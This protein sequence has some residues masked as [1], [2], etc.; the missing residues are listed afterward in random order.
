MA[1]TTIDD[2]SDLGGEQHIKQWYAEKRERYHCLIGELGA[3]LRGSNYDSCLWW[4]RYNPLN[5]CQS[6]TD[7]TK[8]TFAANPS[9]A[10]NPKKRKITTLARLIQRHFVQQGYS[11]TDKEIARI[12][13]KFLE[14]SK[15]RQLR[16]EILEGDAILDAYKKAIGG[17]S[18]MTERQ[19][20]KVVLYAENSDIIKLVTAYDGKKNEKA[21]SARAL[22]WFLKDKLILDRIYRSG[23]I[24]GLPIRE[25][26]DKYASF[27]E[28]QFPKLTV[29]K[30]KHNDASH[31]D[32]YSEVYTVRIKEPEDGIWPYLDSFNS[33]KL[34]SKGVYELTTSGREGKGW[35]EVRNQNG[36]GP[37]TSRCDECD[38]RLHEDNLIDQD[39]DVFCGPCHKKL[40]AKCDDCGDFC[41]IDDNL[42]Q[43]GTTYRPKLKRIDVERYCYTCYR[44]NNRV[45]MKCADIIH[46]NII[47]V[48]E[49]AEYCPICYDQLKGMNNN[50]V[51]KRSRN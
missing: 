12:E 45:C 47:K 13:S 16:F 44:D 42:R 37:N 51:S 20:D 35:Y 8:F 49:H 25:V 9:D 41:H 34:V 4:L 2:F 6:R 24:S 29:I 48:H 1:E 33:A 28:S 32:A 17:H 19:S 15:D 18:C 5:I 23:R 43:I 14:L 22:I 40:F 38:A 36:D 26:Q 46:K 39:G 3:T 31:G 27:L 30:R 50:R 21:H 11:I 10:Y 7:P